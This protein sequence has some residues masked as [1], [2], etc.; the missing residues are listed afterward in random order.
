MAVQ[1]KDWYAWVDEMPP[2][3]SH[4]HV[5]GEL[6]APNPG[7]EALLTVKE[8]QGINPGVL[9]LDL[10]LIQKPGMW[11]QVMTWVQARYEKTLVPVS[12]KYSEV[13][14]SL[15]GNPLITV[16]VVEIH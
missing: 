1:Q 12:P 6:L 14:V 16:P 10:H 5:V 4:L 13:Q 9:L 15:N 7:V 2:P 3:P 8:P 11:P